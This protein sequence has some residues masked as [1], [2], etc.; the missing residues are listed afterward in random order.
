MED[1][2]IQQVIKKIIEGRIGMNIITP[3]DNKPQ[4]YSFNGADVLSIRALIAEEPKICGILKLNCLEAFRQ[5]DFIKGESVKE[6]DQNR[7]SM[8]KHAINYLLETDHKDT[9]LNNMQNWLKQVADR[10]QKGRKE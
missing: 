2:Y 4:W 9:V 5:L 1:K 8:L 10:S 6:H 7:I 3:A